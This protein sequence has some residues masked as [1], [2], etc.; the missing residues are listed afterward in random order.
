MSKPAETRETFT[1]EA[2]PSDIENGLFLGNPVLDNVVSCLIAM[3]AEM[4]AT[5]R[6][7]KVMEAVIAQHGIPSEKIEQY[8]PTAEQNAEWEKERDRFVTLVLGSLSN[9]RFRSIGADFPHA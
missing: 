7:L 2:I 6:R 3:S 1:A 8:A 5:K 9:E 4:W